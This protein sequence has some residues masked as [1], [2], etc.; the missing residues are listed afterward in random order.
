MLNVFNVYI[1]NICWTYTLNISLLIANGYFECIHNEHIQYKLN[2][3]AELF[4]IS[5]KSLSLYT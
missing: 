1:E 4:N 3:Y 2:V 5:N